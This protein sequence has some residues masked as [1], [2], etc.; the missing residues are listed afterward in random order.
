MKHVDLISLEAEIAQ[1]ESI[2]AKKR[3]QYESV[4]G[5]KQ[6]ATSL[7][8]R[9]IKKHDL[10]IKDIE[11]VLANVSA[12]RIVNVPQQRNEMVYVSK[13]QKMLDDWEFLV[14][15]RSRGI[16][17]GKIWAASPKRIEAILR[18]ASSELANEI[19]EVRRTKW[20]A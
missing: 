14:E 6:K 1:I 5:I 18:S 3:A 4:S 8:I 11:L 16:V 20:A 7:V 2:L 15:R 13:T 17:R 9:I 12:P 10:K 19:E